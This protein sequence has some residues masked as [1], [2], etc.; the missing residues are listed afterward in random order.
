MFRNTVNNSYNDDNYS[1][2]LRDANNSRGKVLF[3]NASQHAKELNLFESRLNRPVGGFFGDLLKRIKNVLMPNGKLTDLFATAER[4]VTKA[5]NAASTASEWIKG[6]KQVYDTISKIFVKDTVIVKTDQPAGSDSPIIVEKMSTVSTDVLDAVSA[7]ESSAVATSSV[8]PAV[9]NS[10]LKKASLLKRDLLQSSS[11]N[12]LLRRTQD[13]GI[14]MSS[15]QISSLQ[16][17]FSSYKSFTD[18]LQSKMRLILDVM[19]GFKGGSGS[20]ESFGWTFNPST[21]VLDLEAEASF[22]VRKIQPIF[23]D[24]D[25]VFIQTVLSHVVLQ[26]GFT[27]DVE[28]IIALQNPDDTLND[29]QTLNSGL[30]ISDTLAEIDVQ[31]DMLESLPYDQLFSKASGFSTTMLNIKNFPSSC[32]ALEDVTLGAP[33][34]IFSSTS[35]KLS[36]TTDFKKGD[37]ICNPKITTLYSDTGA[38]VNA[39]IYELLGTSIRMDLPT[40]ALLWQSIW[41][42]LNIVEYKFA[43]FINSP[44]GRLIIDVHVTH[45]NKVTTDNSIALSDVNIPGSVFPLYKHW[46][47]MTC[48]K[49]ITTKTKLIAVYTLFK[50]AAAFLSRDTL[51]ATAI[52]K[53]NAMMPMRLR[54]LMEL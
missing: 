48:W 47:S 5:N 39:K 34:E 38:I 27:S 25:R 29:I 24:V 52:E 8:L 54:R 18:Q 32:V 22:L 14:K 42:I 23:P 10:L 17:L 31:K 16:D 37:C 6:G 28:S 44:D 12:T 2:F 35:G 19:D 53:N 41:G 20:T 33:I 4:Y 45:D 43:D 9:T 26:S 49:N 11:N 46:M 3:A 51:H 1:N 36:V 13:S 30:A 40:P 7:I 50:L 21:G 15:Q